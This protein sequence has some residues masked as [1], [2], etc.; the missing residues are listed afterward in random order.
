MIRFNPSVPTP[1]S[2]GCVF[3][4]RNGF[5]IIGFP[6]IPIFGLM[7]IFYMKEGFKLRAFIVA[8]FTGFVIILLMRTGRTQSSGSESIY[9]YHLDHLGTPLKL[10]DQNK[11]V[12]WSIEC[13]P[14]MEFCIEEGDVFQPLRFPGQY[15]DE[16]TGLHYN[17]NRY[18][19]PDW[20]R[21]IEVDPQG[22]QNISF[23][24]T[25]EFLEI[26]YTFQNQ[27]SYIYALNNPL[28]FIDIAGLYYYKPGVSEADP[29]VNRILNCMDS[30]LNTNLG[31]S[32]GS[33]K[34]GHSPG[35]AHYIG[36]AADISVRMNPTLNTKD[37][38]RCAKQCGA[39]C[40]WDETNKPGVYPHWHIQSIPC[41]N[42][43]EGDLS[44]FSKCS[45]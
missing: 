20:G 28:S 16:E 12:V 38:M 25:E 42:G 9:Y 13:S 43:S 5:L 15:Y 7:F 21:Y 6:L 11:D 19:K 23:F 22:L 18:Y 17:W 10:T 2:S 32:G 35:S 14:F 30:C 4:G 26:L 44:K 8:I 24:E 36:K 33:E 31:I 29:E 40:A 34:I 1:Q 39:R 3:A 37:V 27:H 41:K 45:K